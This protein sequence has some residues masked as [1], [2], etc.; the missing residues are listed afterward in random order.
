MRE[1][2]GRLGA[3]HGAT[4]NPGMWR[5]DQRKVTPKYNAKQI[6]DKTL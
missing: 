5:P 3:Q 4:A 2:H 1:P 6:F